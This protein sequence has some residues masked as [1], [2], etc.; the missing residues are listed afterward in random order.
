MYRTCTLLTSWI[1]IYHWIEQDPPVSLA[2]T[3]SSKARQTA[4]V[5]NSGFTLPSTF[6]FSLTCIINAAICNPS[7]STSELVRGGFL[8]H[9]LIKDVYAH[10]FSIRYFCWSTIF[11]TASI[12]YSSS[13]LMASLWMSSKSHRDDNSSIVIHC[14]AVLALYFPK[15]LRGRQLGSA[16]NSITRRCSRWI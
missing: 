5:T 1:T 2:G 15:T 3:F 7:L 4:V 8:E 10:C 14:E 12:S 13:C 6:N 16:A 11:S 9:R